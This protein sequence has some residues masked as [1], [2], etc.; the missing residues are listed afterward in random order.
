VKDVETHDAVRVLAAYGADEKAHAREVHARK[1]AG[2]EAIALKPAAAVR[3]S[4]I[5]SA[6]GGARLHDWGQT[7]PYRLA[8][9]FARAAAERGAAFF[10]RSRARRIKVRRQDVE[11]QVEGGTLTAETACICTGE[12][13]DLFRSLARHLHA[14][15]RYLALTDRLPAPVRQQIGTRARV[16]ADTESPAHLVRWTGDDRVII[17]GADQPRTP[18]RGRNRILVQRTGQLMYELSR[19]YPAISGV[20]PTHGWDLPLAATADGAMYAGPHRNYP[21][22]LFAWGTRHDPAQAFLASR[23]L[24]RHFLGAADRDDAYFAFTRG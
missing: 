5:E 21:R 8:L 19:L 15:E 17:A 7:N 24:L 11:I 9:A 3:E 14:G 1:D 13:G 22:H 18:E 23:I 2:F 12:P 10:E 4:G 16:V 6:R 20:M